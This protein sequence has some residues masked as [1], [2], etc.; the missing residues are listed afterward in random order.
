MCLGQA[1]GWERLDLA[2]GGG[3]GG[4]ASKL[5]DLIDV[6]ITAPDTGNVLTYNGTAWVNGGVPDPGTY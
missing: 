4:G 2:A 5:S 1:R 6:M 3:G